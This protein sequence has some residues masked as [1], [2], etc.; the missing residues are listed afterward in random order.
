MMSFY[1]D[2]TRMTEGN[3]AIF[4]RKWSH[5]C[6]HQRSQK[7]KTGMGK[8]STFLCE[9]KKFLTLC[10]KKKNRSIILRR[11]DK[12]CA[13]ARQADSRGEITISHRRRRG[14]GRE[15]SFSCR[16]MIQKVLPS[17]RLIIYSTMSR[18]LVIGYWWLTIGETVV[19]GCWI[20]DQRDGHWLVTLWLVIGDW[21]SVFHDSRVVFGDRNHQWPFT[22]R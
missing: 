4:S 7:F 16:G 19:A 5:P 10:V 13:A 6:R 8:A 15:D 17:P 14:Q 11:P 12:T 1:C 22:Y 3:G 18:C 20:G 2:G 9:K 21:W